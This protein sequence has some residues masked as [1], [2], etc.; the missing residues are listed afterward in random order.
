MLFLRKQKNIRGRYQSPRDRIELG[1][2]KGKTVVNHLSNIFYL[3][4]H[5][6]FKELSSNSSDSG[7]FLCM[8]A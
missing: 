4:I 6:S 7:I 5:T 3:S 8:K 1:I 2:E